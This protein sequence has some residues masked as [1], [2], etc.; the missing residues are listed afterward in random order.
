MKRSTT[1]VFPHEINWN[2]I[3]DQNVSIERKIN[4]QIKSAFD[5]FIVYFSIQFWK[6]QLREKQ[7][8]NQ[9]NN[10]RNN[11]KTPAKQF[12]FHLNISL[13]QVDP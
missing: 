1:R 6:K 7:I 10:Q 5:A 4:S 2:Q 3:S 11:Y 8:I 13:A 12:F 9:I